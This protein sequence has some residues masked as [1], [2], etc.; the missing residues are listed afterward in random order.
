MSIVPTVI[1][2]N[3]AFGDSNGGSYN[4]T[5][6]NW[7]STRYQG[8]GFYGYSDGLHTFGYKLTDFEGQFN[9]QA[10]LATNPTED[11]WFDTGSSFGDDTSPFTGSGF[12]NV[13]GNFVWVRVAVIN[14]TAGTINRVLYN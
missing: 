13:T 2:S 7:Y 10:S 4:G 11:D 12:I 1:I 14:F 5:D 3:T 9:I 8:R 6:E